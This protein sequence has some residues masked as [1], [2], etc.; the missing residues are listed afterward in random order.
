MAAK[1]EPDG[2]CARQRRPGS[3]PSKPAAVWANT[4]DN[5]YAASVRTG[6]TESQHPSST[7]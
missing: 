3:I 2:R 5:P 7:H 1:H 4:G 6:Q